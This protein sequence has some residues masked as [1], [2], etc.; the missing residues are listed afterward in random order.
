MGAVSALSK[1]VRETGW[2]VALVQASFL[3]SLVFILALPFFVSV[4]VF[5]FSEASTSNVFLY[6]AELSIKVL[7]VVAVRVTGFLAESGDLLSHI[8]DAASCA[9]L[10]E[11]EISYDRAVVEPM[12]EEGI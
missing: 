4:N 3:I 6:S 8:G 5:A 10:E 2:S 1:T 11:V 7:D 12:V 9:L